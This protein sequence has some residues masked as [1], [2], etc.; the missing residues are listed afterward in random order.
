[1]EQLLTAYRQHAVDHGTNTLEGDAEATNAAYDHLQEVF[2]AIVEA[3]KGAELFQFYDDSDPW[4]QS[5]AASHTLE[6]DEA[7]ALA[8]LW[9]LERA[10]IPHVSTSAKYTIQGW[11]NGELRFLPPAS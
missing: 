10:G 1:M 3:G 4:V 11:K 6:I 7:Q 9:E 2:L 8:K 5:W